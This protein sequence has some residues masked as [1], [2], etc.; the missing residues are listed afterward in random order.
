MNVL[1][2]IIIGLLLTLTSTGSVS[3]TA[4]WDNSWD[5]RFAVTTD[6]DMVNHTESN[7]PIK[8]F[9]NRDGFNEDASDLRVTDSSGNQL[10]REIEFYDSISNNGS[11]IFNANELSNTSNDVFYIYGGNTGASEPA[12]DSTYGSD[13]VWDAEV[14]NAYLF[15][16]DGD[17][18]TSNDRHLT[19]TGTITYPEDDY[20]MAVFADWTNI[21]KMTGENQGANPNGD[22]YQITARF[23]KDGVPTA[24]YGP[25]LFTIATGNQ[26]FGSN[27]GKDTGYPQFVTQDAS[28]S[29]HIQSVNVCDDVWHTLTFRRT[30]TEHAVIVDGV[31][32]SESLTVRDST[33]DDLYMGIRDNPSYDFLNEA[34][35][36]MIFVESTAR[37]DDYESTRHNNL[38]NPTA[39]GV[40][41]FFTSIGATEWDVP[42]TPILVGN[43][44]GN[45]W[46][47]YEIASSGGS[48]TDSFNVSINSSW[49]NGTTQ[50][51]WYTATG[52]HGSVEIIAYA[53]N[54]TEDNLSVISVT[55]TV[56]V[57]NNPIT[58]TDVSSSYS[59]QS[60]ETLNINANYVDIDSDTGTFSDNSSDW[61]IDTSTGIVSWITGD[62][63]VGIQ[64]YY[65]NV[66]DGYGSTSTI[67]FSVTVLCNIPQLI[68]LDNNISDDLYPKIGKNKYINF[69][70]TTFNI[71]SGSTWH[72]SIDGVAQNHNYSNITTSWSSTGQVNISLYISSPICGNTGSIIAYPLVTRSMTTGADVQPTYSEEPMDT[73]KEG[74]NSEYPDIKMVLWGAMLPFV[75]DM[76]VTFFIFIYILPMIA[77]WMPQ[78][79]L[80]IPVGITIIFSVVILGSLPEEFIKVAQATILLTTVGIFYRI[81]KSRR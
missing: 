55:D 54:L 23:R 69:Y 62:D 5:F 76:G 30:G 61:N 10:A 71:S 17:D 44:S 40:D 15:D 43:S 66:S 77:M 2:I 32:T 36:G 24:E 22:N 34:W 70:A 6:S 14:E 35:I 60:G 41:P 63:D 64:Y 26:V 18:S 79:K 42:S 45:F 81:Y 25:T 37:D 74:I 48:G 7:F 56:I 50:T 29:S 52:P 72:W 65:I 46:V 1:R 39:T 58:L 13:N 53:Y 16:G 75:N 12:P 31:K 57:S 8:V 59:V 67:H 4:F 11:V 78:K 20:G 51:V 68:S 73:I 80:L 28:Y 27:I 21:N 47:E 19:E 9:F 49:T 33:T 3:A 38:N